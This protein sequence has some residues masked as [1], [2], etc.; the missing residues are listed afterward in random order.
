M[1]DLL[2]TPVFFVLTWVVVGLMLREY[3][4]IRA[5][6]LVFAPVV[7]ASRHTSPTWLGRLAWASMGASTTA[8]FFT[9]AVLPVAE[10]PRLLRVPGTPGVFPTENAPAFFV[11]TVTPNSPTGTPTIATAT[12][13]ITNSPVVTA[14]SIITRAQT[15]TPSPSIPGVKV[16]PSSISAPASVIQTSAPAT[17]AVAQPTV[18]PPTQVPPTV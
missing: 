16:S 5:R 15:V 8:L 3:W 14:T 12:A 18:I 9:F 11:N 13:T 10:S 6:R 2:L 4:M 7:V 17:A 1:N